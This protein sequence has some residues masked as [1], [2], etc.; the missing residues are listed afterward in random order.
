MVFRQTGGRSGTLARVRLFRR[1]MM[2]MPRRSRG[3]ASPAMAVKPRLADPRPSSRG[4][5][6]GW[7]LCQQRASSPEDDGRRRAKGSCACSA[8]GWPR[9]NATRSRPRRSRT[10]PCL[11]RRRSETL[12]ECIESATGSC[13]RSTLA[14]SRAEMPKRFPACRPNK[15]R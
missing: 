12:G 1:Q 13:F 14:W 15:S 6:Q 8:R 5:A 7:W 3:Q 4:R 2:A 11:F 9:A 10:T